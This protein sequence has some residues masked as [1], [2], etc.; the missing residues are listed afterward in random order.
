MT[1][2]FTAPAGLSIITTT[3]AE[4]PA[5]NKALSVYTATGATGFSLGL[6]IGGLLTEAGWRWVFFLPAP[7][8]LIA[9][10]AGMQ[11]RARQRAR[12]A[13]PARLRR[14][15]RRHD[16][17]RDAAARL[18]ARRTR[19]TRAG[20]RRARSRR[21]SAPPRCWPRSSSASSARRRRSCGSASCAR[22]AL[23]RANLAAMALFGSWVGFQ[24]IATL[25]MQQLR[26]W[27]AL[28]TGLAIFPAGVLVAR[29]LDAHRAARHALRRHAADRRRPGLDRRGLRAL[30]ADR[31]GV[32][33]PASRCCRRSCSRASAS[34]SRSGR[35]TSPRRAA[36]RPGEQGLAGGLLNT[37]FQFG[38]ALALAVTTAVINANTGDG[39]SP[40][41]VLDGFQPALFVPVIVAVLGIVAIGTSLRVARASTVAAVRRRAGRGGVAA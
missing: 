17:G 41:A 14:R 5:R 33:L 2:A 6:V 31:A 38:G 13:H 26:G 36:S 12:S 37:S 16:H 25:Y 3:F 4:G 34:R 8:A 27:S 39:G 24:F 30:P 19:R 28:E 21:S 1:A 40:Q 10:I 20:R 22:A 9:L 15:R 32:E 35:S 11:A 7:V 29:H 18:H 23:V